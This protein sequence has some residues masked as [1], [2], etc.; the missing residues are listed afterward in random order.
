MEECG[1]WSI[2]SVTFLVPLELDCQRED[3]LIHQCLHND[4]SENDDAGLD[5]EI[6][7]PGALMFRE[8]PQ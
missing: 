1:R 3:D 4:T 7:G 8:A 6:G 2:R 5:L